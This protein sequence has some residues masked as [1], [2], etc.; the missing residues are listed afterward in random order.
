MKAF[1][2]FGKVFVF[3]F[4]PNAVPETYQ[5]SDID[6]ACNFFV[7][8]IIQLVYHINIFLFL[9]C[10][11]LSAICKASLDNY[12]AFLHFFFL[13]MVL[14]TTS[15]TMSQTSVHSSS[16]TLTLRSNP[17]NLFVTSTVRGLIQVIPE[18]SSVFPYFLI[19]VASSQWCV[20]PQRGQ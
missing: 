5:Q 9:L 10:F 1:K 2:L 12:F 18:W 19:G 20:L 14:I 6:I 4:F 3:F 13:G 15:H 7:N 8:S 17:L 16:G 11:L